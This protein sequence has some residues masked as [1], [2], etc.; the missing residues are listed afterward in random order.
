M[1]VLRPE[2]IHP[3]YVVKDTETNRGIHSIIM[4]KAD[5]TGRLNVL[6]GR[7]VRYSEIQVQLP[8]LSVKTILGISRYGAWPQCVMPN[9]GYLCHN[10]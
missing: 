8:Q 7:G 5:V 1:K 6:S 2:S 9:S 4:K 10:P 3:M